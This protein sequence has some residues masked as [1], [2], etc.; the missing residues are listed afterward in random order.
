MTSGQHNAA[1]QQ[2]RSLQDWDHQSQLHVTPKPQ[3]P[4]GTKDRAP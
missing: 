3:S 1:N 2:Q 4:A